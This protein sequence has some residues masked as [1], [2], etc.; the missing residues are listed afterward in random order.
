MPF[1]IILTPLANAQPDTIDKVNFEKN[2]SKINPLFVYLLKN[3][4]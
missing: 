4:K 3:I 1:T 2:Y